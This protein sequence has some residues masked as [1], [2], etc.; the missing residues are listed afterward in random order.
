V[1]ERESVPAG[2]AIAPSGVV[3]R[4]ARSRLRPEQ[5]VAVAAGGALG[6]GLRYE[7]VMGFPAPAGRIPWITLA[8]NISGAFVLGV[9]LTLV[10]ERW[11]PTRYVRLFL[12][13]GFLGAYTTFST[14]ALESDLLLKD[15]RVG[16]AILYDV[17]SLVA[18][19]VAAFLGIFAARTWPAIGRTTR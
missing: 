17:L 13:I 2:S 15:G 3:P 14:F 11:P 19:L 5:L 7:L 12:A 9:L 6:G 18:G 10:L 1:T 4:P 16:A 8:I